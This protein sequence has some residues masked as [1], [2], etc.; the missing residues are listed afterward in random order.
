M[1]STGPRSR[2]RVRVAL[3]AAGLLA[4]LVSPSLPAAAAPVRYEAETATISQ[5]VVESNHTGFSGTGF[6]NYDNLVG[7]S[8]EWTVNAAAAGSATLAFGFAN[9]TTTD[10]PMDITVNGTLVAD[11]LS[12]PGTGSWD[13]WEIRS[14]TAA[15]TAGANT[16]RATATTANGGPNVDYLD[17][18]MVAPTN[19]Y[20]A[21]DATISQ[22]VV[23]SDHAGF[24]GTGFVNYDN[25]AGSYVQWTVTAASAGST[26]L[27]IRFANGTTTDRPMDITVNGTLLADELSF[28]GTGSWD[29]WQTRSVTAALTAGANTVRATATTA[30]GGPNVDKLTVGGAPSR[31]ITVSSISQLQAAADR[32]QPGDRIELVDGV[33]T[34]TGT[35][36]LTRS[37]TSSAPVTVAAQHVGGAEIRGSAGFAFESVGHVAVEGFRLTHSAAVN[38]PASSHHV[39]LSRNVIQLSN[40]GG[41][42]VTVTG[43]DCEID[44]NTFQNKSTEGVFLQISGPGDSAMAQRTH[45]HHNYFFNH[46]FDG[47]NGGES[48]RL[49]YSFRQLS[50]AFATIEYNLF[51]RANGDSEAVSVKSADNIVRFN[52]LRDS[53]GSIVL[54]H[55]NRTLVEANLMLGGSSGIRFYDN[56]HVIINNVIQG[57]SGQIIAGSGTIADD[58]TGSTAHARPDRVLVAFNTVVGNRTNLLQVG[59]GT[60]DL[61]PNSCTFANNIFVGGGSGALLDIDEGT[62]LV[63]QGNIVWAGTGGNVP[64][65]GYRVVNPALVVDAGGLYRLASGSSPA[66]D[67][68]AGS[69]PQVSR[70]MDL[71]ARS[72]AKDVGADE[73]ATSGPLRRPLTTADVGPSGP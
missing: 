37:G 39:R 3:V 53:R 47:S 14:V 41:N 69:Y 40:S 28:P 23:E 66:V 46:T 26:S 71:Q 60:A 44:H 9:G 48:I 64:S 56:D 42:W 21:E 11:E 59:Q 15:L 72:G 20:Q 18:E 61:G 19:E 65:S 10:R 57:G 45:V 6:V 34:T 51:D 32:A 1:T 38:I 30:N 73:F 54:R 58:T 29:A 17:V 67:T 43:D 4:A 2:R 35:I 63:W 5:G 27:V 8:V 49:G 36:R 50:S 25:V 13:A 16:V 68:A 52:T 33:Y 12:F 31:L 24:T 55:G 70:D 7:S 22:G 62:N